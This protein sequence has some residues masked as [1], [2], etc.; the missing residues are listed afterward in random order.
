MISKLLSDSNV[1]AAVK[2]CD[3]WVENDEFNCD[4]FESRFKLFKS[5]ETDAAIK[6]CNKWLAKNQ[7]DGN[8]YKHKI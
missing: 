3:K 6:F 1:N 7:Y 4:A 2:F 5:N 8:A